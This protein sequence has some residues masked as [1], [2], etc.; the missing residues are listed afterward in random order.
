M[1]V[2]V[3]AMRMVQMSVDQVVDVI[4]VWHRL[5]SAAWTVHMMR[6]VPAAP[7]LGRAPIGI[8]RRHLYRVLID[9]IAVHM[10][11][12]AV[13]EVVHMVAMANGRMPAPGTVLVRVVDVLA[14]GAGAHGWPRGSPVSG[15]G[16]P[17]PPRAPTAYALPAHPFQ[18]WAVSEARQMQGWCP[19]GKRRPTL[20]GVVKKGLPT[21]HRS[22][23]R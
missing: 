13:V 5:V 6:V 22:H 11:Q 7:V 1:V 3:V 15:I 10:M 14:A 18:H 16:R 9:V 8:G 20:H 23:P 21:A 2:A 4:A 12:M 17:L 19:L